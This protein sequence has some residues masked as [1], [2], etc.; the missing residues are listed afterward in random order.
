MWMSDQLPMFEP[1]I[2]A[3]TPSTTSLPASVDS[4]S[5]CASPDGPMT[6]P[7]QQGHAPAR[8][9]QRPAAVQASMIRDTFGR[10]GFGSS[11]SA[12]FQQSLASKLKRRLASGGSILFSETWKPRVTPAGRRYLGLAV[13]GRPTS[14]SGFIGWPTTQSRD[15]HGGGQ[16]QR[17]GERSNLD[18]AAQLAS[19]PTPNTPNGGRSQPA[20]TT[21]TG[22][23]PDGSKAQVCLENVAMLA[24]WP[25][26][27]AQTPAQNGNNAAGSSDSSRKTVALL[28]GWGTPTVS[29]SRGVEYS[30]GNR[31][32]DGKPYTLNLRLPGEAKLAGRGTPRAE[33]VESSGMR[34]ARGVAD[35]LT[36]QS[37]W[38][39]WMTPNTVDAKLGTRNGPGQAQLCHQA[40]LTE[41]GPMPPGF[42]AGTENCAPFSGQLNPSLSR[43][44]MGFPIAWDV[45]ALAS[46]RS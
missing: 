3:A 1:T 6:G 44:L 21:A 30:Y 46:W 41:P 8:A 7:S 5:R 38:A 26:P 9:S 4:A 27:M 43:W 14:G 40:R 35:T 36:A 12:S 22:R 42:P 15:G 32:T 24:G 2:C 29:D 45:A 31:N 23:K 25:T 19:W 28:A 37:S 33:D 18:D 17:Y 34:H 13:S 11:A 16:A 39:G 10:R 20:E